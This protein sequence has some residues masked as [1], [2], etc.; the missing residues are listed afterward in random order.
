MS[1]IGQQRQ[2]EVMAGLHGSL[3]LVVVGPESSGTRVMAKALEEHPKIAPA[4]VGKHDD[5]LETVWEHLIRRDPVG[6][7]E[8]LPPPAGG[9]LMTRR[10]LPHGALPGSQA[11]FMVFPPLGAF[12]EVCQDVGYQ[13]VYIITSRSPHANLHSWASQRNSTQGH[14]AKALQQYHE[15][16]PYILT[17]AHRLCVPYVMTSLEGLIHEGTA[18]ANGIFCMLGLKPIDKDL[19][20]NEDVN[21]KRYTGRLA[22]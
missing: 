10:S 11:E 3:M 9:V 1:G 4:Y 6:A 20:F 8:A 2:V 7:R 14:V 21:Q 15:A 18:Y 16:F 12:T 13:V 5:A 19:Q 17:T 22:A